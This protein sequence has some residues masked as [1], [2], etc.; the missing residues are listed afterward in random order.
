MFVGAPMMAVVILTAPALMAA[1]MG[2]G[3]G[4]SGRAIQILAVGYLALCLG[5]AVGPMVQGIGRPGIQVKAAL[6]ALL[7]HIVLSV[8]MVFTFGFYGV[9]VGTALALVASLLYYYIVALKPFGRPV[10][11]FCAD[12]FWK[13]IAA[14]LVAG[15]LLAGLTALLGITPYPTRLANIALVLAYA[16]AFSALYLVLIRRLRYLD[17]RDVQLA[18]DALRRVFGRFIPASQA[19]EPVA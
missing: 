11:P 14:C 8:A 1:W 13:P 17:A 16:L 6:F 18:R 4:L 5:G 19:H 3:Y 9:L 10:A 7:V 15:A 2:P 12:V